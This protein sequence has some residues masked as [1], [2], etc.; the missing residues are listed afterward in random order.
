MKRGDGSTLVLACFFAIAL[1]ALWVDP[2]P[3]G[4]SVNWK[5]KVTNDTDF[6]CEVWLY[7]SP[8]SLNERKRIEPRSSYTFTTG[9][10]CPLYLEGYISGV[11]EWMKKSCVNGSSYPACGAACWNTEFKTCITSQGHS[12]C[13]Q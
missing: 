9:S 2:A 13:K 12:F 1:L 11:D 4:S 7:V 5:V 10:K 3:A 8:E 6:P